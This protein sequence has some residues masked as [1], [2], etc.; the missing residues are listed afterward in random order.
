[1]NKYNIILFLL[2]LSSFTLVVGYSLELSFFGGT[3]FISY[4]AIHI[5]GDSYPRGSSYAFSADESISFYDLELRGQENT[6]IEFLDTR[7]DSLLI[8]LVTDRL[9]VDGKAAFAANEVTLFIDGSAE[10]IHYSWLDALEL[11]LY[12]GS[13]L[14]DYTPSKYPFN[15]TVSTENS[16]IISD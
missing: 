9:Y 5:D 6:V 4:P 7:R 13:T 2:A 14:P 3:G 16:E 12:E 11:T 1:M 15:I 8:H 10:L